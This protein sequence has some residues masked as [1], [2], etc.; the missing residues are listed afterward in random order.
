MSQVIA[1]NHNRFVP[2]SRLGYL[3]AAHRVEILG[4][5]RRFGAGNVE[6]FGSVATGE[7]GPGSDIDLLVDIPEDMG[8]F[9]LSKMERAVRDVVGVPVDL[10]PSRLLKPD[11]RRSAEL[12][13]VPL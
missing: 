11:V 6:V 5:V 3:L 12:A 7:D 13:A 1:A 10:V 8:L 2:S 4:I 9:S